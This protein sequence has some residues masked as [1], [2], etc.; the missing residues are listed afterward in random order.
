MERDRDGKRREGER[1]VANGGEGMEFRGVEIDAPEYRIRTVR[2]YFT[3][4]QICSVNFRHRTPHDEL[5]PVVWRTQTT[6]KV[7]LDKSK[8]EANG[9]T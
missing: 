1:K 9:E 6:C 2:F 8:T 4:V 7:S 3:T 5:I